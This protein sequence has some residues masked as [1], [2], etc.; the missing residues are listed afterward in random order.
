MMGLRRVGAA[1]ALTL[2]LM[3][4]GSS[5]TTK[6]PDPG[7]TRSCPGCHDEIIDTNIK[8]CPACDSPLP[9]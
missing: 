7:P 9:N 3:G 5:S 6:K 4:C 1:I 8:K 2:V